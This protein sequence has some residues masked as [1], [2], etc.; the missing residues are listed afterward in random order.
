MASDVHDYHQQQD[1]SKIIYPLRHELYTY[2]LCIQFFLISSWSLIFDSP[3]LC[4]L[5]CPWFS[6]N[7]ALSSL[8]MVSTFYGTS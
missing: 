6:R 1:I 4:P 5:L 3:F 2:T 8:L 7:F